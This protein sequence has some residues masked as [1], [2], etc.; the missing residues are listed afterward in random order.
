MKIKFIDTKEVRDLMPY[1]CSPEEAVNKDSPAW[2]AFSEGK[3]YHPPTF[4]YG[5]NAGDY[6]SPL[7]SEDGKLWYYK[8]RQERPTRSTVIAVREDI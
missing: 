7:V 3:N 2:K 1:H 6:S 8:V 4:K 5:T